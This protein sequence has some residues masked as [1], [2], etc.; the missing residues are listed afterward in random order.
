IRKR[1]KEKQ[2][3]NVE[4]ILGKEDDPKLP[5]NAVDTILMVDVYHEF[6]FPYEMTKAMV[7]ALK[8]GGRLVFVEYRLEDPKGYIKLVHKMTEKQVLKEMEAH[9]L[10]WLKTYN[11]LPAQ[12]V[13]VFK[14]LADGE[15]V[16]K[17]K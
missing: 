6:E 14:K 4:P 10:K 15:K 5:A 17:S 2:V 1:M 8:P 7:K 11:D 13:V 16:E 3:N 12:H 9:A